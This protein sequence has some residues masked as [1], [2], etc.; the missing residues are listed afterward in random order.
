MKACVQGQRLTT[1]VAFTPVTDVLTYLFT[2]SQ[3]LAAAINF[4]S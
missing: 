1:V 3:H 2:Y 4:I